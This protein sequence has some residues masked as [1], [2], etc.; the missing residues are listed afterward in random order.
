MNDFEVMPAGTGRVLQQALQQLERGFA[1]Q[2]QSEQKLGLV[3][4]ARQAL[5]ALKQY[6]P[7]HGN[8]D[9]MADAVTALRAA[10]AHEEPKPV[11]WTA[12]EIE[13]LD[14]M[15]EVQLRHAAQCDG[16]ANRTMA[17]RQKVWDME[18][19]TLLRKIKSGSPRR[20]W[21]SLSE[22]EREQATGWSVEHIEAKL[23]EK[24]A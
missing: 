24:N 22:E 11:A 13:L 21:Q 20:E 19:V 7:Q 6:A 23:K 16:I 2:N 3:G 1:G 5:E 4:A 12:R 18:R 17:E 15:I 14:G 8:P 10:L 9:D